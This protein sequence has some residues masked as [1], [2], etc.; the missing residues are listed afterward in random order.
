MSLNISMYAAYSS[1]YILLQKKKIFIIWGL[2]VTIKFGGIIGIW[3]P[4]NDLRIILQNLMILSNTILCSNERLRAISNII[5][6]SSTTIGLKNIPSD[7]MFLGCGSSSG[8]TVDG[9]DG[10]DFDHRERV[11]SQYQ[12]R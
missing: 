12:I 4:L 2:P 1:N 10:S 7:L 5:S 11:A 9:T 6:S 3:A 8:H